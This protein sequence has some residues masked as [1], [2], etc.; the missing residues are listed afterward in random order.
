MPIVLST[1]LWLL[2]KM[3]YYGDI[4]PN[5]FYA[6]VASVASVRRG[7]AF[8]LCFLWVYWLVPFVP[9]GVWGVAHAFRRRD[10]GALVL[11]AALLAWLTYVVRI[12]GD[13]MEFRLLV[14]IMPVAFVLLL[15]VTLELTRRKVVRT[16]L[17]V[18]VITGG[19]S[20]ALHSRQPSYAALNGLNIETIGQLEG[21]VVN[22]NEDWAG[23]G[24]VLGE[25]F[26]HNADVLIAVR[27]AGAMPY[28]SGLGCI[29]MHGI[30]DKWVARHG[31]FAGTMPGHQRA[32]PFSYLVRRKVNLVVGHPAIMPIAISFTAFPAGFRYDFF[33]N[34][35]SAA[36]LPRGSCAIAIPV[37][38]EYKAIVLYIRRSATVDAAIR[39]QGWEIVEM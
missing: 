35:R 13:F 16:A 21:R 8:L 37:N 39:E 22:P 12:G 15:W 24:A 1:V 30:N 6:K 32:A 25:A 26:G 5:T 17:I 4:L 11:M 10:S 18:L 20:H 38:D 29:D 28:Y 7:T 23:I 31:Y 19:V 34:L 3:S 36:E 14:P 33:Y 2:W 9:A 27:P